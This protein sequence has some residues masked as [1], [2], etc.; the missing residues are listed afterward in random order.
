MKRNKVKSGRVL[1]VEVSALNLVDSGYV[2]P[3]AH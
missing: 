1:N 2:T 3:L